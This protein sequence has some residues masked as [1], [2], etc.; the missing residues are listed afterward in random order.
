MVLAPSYEFLSALRPCG[1]FNVKP[2]WQPYTSFWV[3]K[4]SFADIHFPVEIPAYGFIVA[5][6]NGRAYSIYQVYGTTPGAVS[7]AGHQLNYMKL[8]P[9][10]VKAVALKVGSVMIALLSGGKGD[11]FRKVRVLAGGKYQPLQKCDGL[12]YDGPVFGIAPDGTLEA[13]KEGRLHMG[14]YV[15][16][17]GMRPKVTLMSEAEA[18][19]LAKHSIVV[20]RNGHDIPMKVTRMDA[21]YAGSIEALKKGDHW[22]QWESKKL[23]NNAKHYG[24]VAKSK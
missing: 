4:E 17:R 21:Q 13:D 8:T 19:K 7:K 10:T 11:V 15:C 5:T 1:N 6:V 20:R 18:R 23:P 3:P 2:F 12:A 16:N 9:K 14:A 24:T 22:F